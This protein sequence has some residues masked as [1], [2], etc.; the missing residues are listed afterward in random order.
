MGLFNADDAI[1]DGIDLLLHHFALLP[2]KLANHK[3]LTVVG[4][5]EYRKGCVFQQLSMISKSLPT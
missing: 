3:Q 4:F 5:A 2:I 1:G